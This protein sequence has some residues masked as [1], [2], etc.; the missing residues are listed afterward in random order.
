VK[1]NKKQETIVKYF[2]VYDSCYR[3]NVD[4]YSDGFPKGSIIYNTLK[5]ENAQRIVDVMNV[6]AKQEG[7]LSLMIDEE[8]LILDILDIENMSDEDI[9]NWVKNK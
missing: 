4:I 5:K 9:I 6:V 7:Q 3:G 1:P 2:T 8:K